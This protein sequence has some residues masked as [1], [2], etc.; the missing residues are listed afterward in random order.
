MVRSAQCADRHIGRTN[1]H[2]GAELA[3]RAIAQR[4]VW[5][6]GVVV[7][8]PTVELTEHRRRIG[9]WME[10]CVVA[11]E[12]LHEGLRHAIRLWALDRRGKRHETDHLCQR[13]GLTCGI[14]RAI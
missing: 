8:E 14:G 1:L 4:L 10:A 13:A 7:F 5:M 11:L 12:G 9:P 3:W 6:D 2:E